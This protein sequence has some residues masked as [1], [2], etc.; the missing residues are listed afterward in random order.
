MLSLLQIVSFRKLRYIKVM[1][2]LLI[3]CVLFSIYSIH[4]Y[5]VG[6][7]IIKFDSQCTA[8]PNNLL[9]TIS[10]KEATFSEIEAVFRGIN[11]KLGGTYIPQNKRK[12][13]KY[14]E[15]YR[16]AL[17]EMA[18]ALVIGSTKPAA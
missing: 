14:L 1:Y 7:K 18:V 6:E 9:K 11:V 2:I 15:Y 5:L 4:V 3:V 8:Y 13:F 16:N 12:L 17:C 10:E